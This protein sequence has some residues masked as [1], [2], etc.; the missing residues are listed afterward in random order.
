MSYCLIFLISAWGYLSPGIINTTVLA[1]AGFVR[2]KA[3]LRLILTAALFEGMYFF[4]I[5]LLLK[6]VFLIVLVQYATVCAAMLI[7]GMGIWTI[8]DAIR[9]TTHHASASLK[10]AYFVIFLHPQQFPFWLGWLTALNKYGITEIQVLPGALAAALG[11]FTMLAMYSLVGKK[12]SN[13]FAL[14]PKQIWIG[15]G[16]LYCILGLVLLF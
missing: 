16:C 11:C 12:L 13:F 7:I 3:L 10:R 1:E 6:Q 4:L 8:K 2:S 14:Y 9:Q 15:I 5:Q